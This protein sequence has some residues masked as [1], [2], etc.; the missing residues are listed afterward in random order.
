MSNGLQINDHYPW[1]ATTVDKQEVKAAYEN[2]IVIT[3]HGYDKKFFDEFQLKFSQ[4][5]GMLSTHVRDILKIQNI[6]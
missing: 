1:E 2:A 3:A 5:T 6:R 4:E